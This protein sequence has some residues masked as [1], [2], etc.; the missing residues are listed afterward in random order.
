MTPQ[1]NWIGRVFI[2]LSLDGFIA[3]EDG[4]IN[5]LTDPEPRQHTLVSSSARAETWSSFFPTIDHI[6]MGRGTYEKI[7]TFGEWPYTGKTVIVLSRTLTNH[8]ER[9]SIARTVD[10]AC[11]ALGQGNAKQVY[12]DGGRTIQAF[13]RE[14]LINELTLSH[15]PILLGTGLPLFGTLDAEV[16]LT[17]LA[18]HASED[19][20]V[21]ATY[22]VDPPSRER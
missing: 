2:G 7:V 12:V 20:M 19:G 9:V 21:H 14:G 16:R 5:W 4:D 3:R 13:L 15:A 1:K 6:V 17:L 10:E 8:D 11:R 18:S 22:R